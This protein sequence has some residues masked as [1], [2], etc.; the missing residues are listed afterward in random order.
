MNKTNKFLTVI[1]A[2]A[3][4]AVVEYW[5]CLIH[6]SIAVFLTSIVV[7]GALGDKRYG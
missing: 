4:I 5:L 3:L 6:W 7:I 1:F 2:I